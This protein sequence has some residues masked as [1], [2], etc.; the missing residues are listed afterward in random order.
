MATI[1]F[2]PETSAPAATIDFQ[3][4]SAPAASGIDFQPEQS[5]PA[6]NPRDFIKPA[7]GVLTNSGGTST[8]ITPDTALGEDF[9]HD[10]MA[11]AS[12]PAVALPKFTVNPDDSKVMAVAKSAAN[13]GISLP[14]FMESPL[15]VATMG[16]G[17]VIPKTVAALFTA[18]TA[19]SVGQQATQM[20]SQ[21][22]T[23]KPAEKAAALTDISGTTLLATTLGHHAAGKFADAIDTRVNPAGML[24]RELGRTPLNA[25]AAAEIPPWAVG[26]TPPAPPAEAVSPEAL[27]GL[28]SAMRQRQGEALKT[29]VAAPEPPAATLTP[30]PAKVAPTASQSAAQPIPAP[31]S[32]AQLAELPPEELTA[33]YEQHKQL[34][35]QAMDDGKIQDAVYLATQGQFYREALQNKS[36]PQETAAPPSQKGGTPSEVSGVQAPALQATQDSAVN[37]KGTSKEQIVKPESPPVSRAIPPASPATAP[38]EPV[39]PSI[40]AKETGKSSLE[41][42]RTG[43]VDT[44]AQGSLNQALKLKADTW[45]RVQ[46]IRQKIKA[47]PIQTGNLR[48]DLIK[49]ESAH[50]EALQMERDARAGIETRANEQG[51]TT[52]ATPPAPAEKPAAVQKVAS[53]M[54]AAAKEFHDLA[55]S[56]APEKK[57][58]SERTLDA[59][60]SADAGKNNLGTMGIKGNIERGKAIKKVWEAA[61]KELGLDPAQ[62][63]REAYRATHIEKIRT[64]AKQAGKFADAV[65]DEGDDSGK[66]S[67][68]S[69]ELKVGDSLDIGGEKVKVVAVRHDHIEL[70]DGRKFGKQTVPNGKTLYVEGYEPKGEPSGELIPESEMPFNL[71]GEQ[72]KFVEPTQETTQHGGE[73]LTQN[74]LFRIQEIVKDIDPEKSA[75]A[76]EKLYGGADKAAQTIARQLA[77]MA[78]DPKAYKSFGKEHRQRLESVVALLKERSGDPSSGKLGKEPPEIV[79]GFGGGVKPPKPPAEVLPPPESPEEAAKQEKVMTPGLEAV[80]NAHQGVLSLLFPTA[81]SADH[82]HAAETLGAKLGAMARRQEASAAQLAQSSKVFDRLGVENPKLAPGDNPGIKFMSDMSQ[83][84]PMSP[85][86]EAI[87]KLVEKQFDERTKALE[88][89][90]A[91]LQKV[92]ENYFPGMWTRESRM[93]FNAAMEKLKFPEGFDINEATPEQKAAIKAQVDEFM[94]GGKGSE[95]DMLSYITRTPMKGKESFR[96]EKVFD[97]IMTGAEVGLRPLSTN[98]I[99]LVKGKLA[100]MDR[101]IMANQFFQ[102]LK[103]EGKLEIISPYDEVPDGWVKVNDKYGTIYGAPTVTIPEHVDAAVYDGLVKF[104]QSIGVKHERSMKFPAGPGN[105]AL[106]L[107]Y[108]GQNFIRSKFATELSVIAHEIGH[109]IDYK[110]DLWQNITGGEKGSER[111]SLIQKDLR[112][113]ADMTGDRGGKV[114]SKPEKIAQMV[115]AYVHAPDAMRKEAPTVFTLFDNFIRSKPELKPLSDIKPGIALKK[116]T[117]E[118]YVG[119]PIMGY[120]IVPKATGDVLNNY[121]SSSLYN[122]QYFGGL[123]KAW[124]STANVL[125]QSQLGLGSAFHAGFTTSDVQISAGANLIKDIYGVARGNRSLSDLGGTVKDWVTAAGRTAYQGDKILNAWRNPDGVMSP[126]VAQI[127][128]AA[129]LAGGGFHMEHGMTTEQF[130]KMQRNWYSGEHLK[131]A[132]RSPIAMTELMMKPIMEWLVPRQKA[133][134]FADLAGRIIEHNP[135]KPLEELTPQFRQAWNRVD[136][137]LGQV[138]YNR[139]FVHNAAKNAAQALIRA[140]GW[141]GGTIAEI[142]GAFPDT[143]RFLREWV[144]TGKLPQDIPDRV[145]YTLSMFATIGAANAIATYAFTGQMPTG[146]D[147]LAFRTGR[148]D[149][150]GNNERFMFPSYVKDVLAYE[151]QPGSTLLNKAHPMFSML[152]DLEKNRDYMGYEIRD[153]NASAAVQAGQSAKFVVKNFEPFWLRGTFQNAPNAQRAAAAYIGIMP[154]PSY[155]DRSPIQNKIAELY[156]ERTGDRLKPYSARDTDAAKKQAHD[157]STMDVYMFRR[158]PKTDQAALREKMTPAELAR[159]H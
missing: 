62:I 150:N 70:E 18:D 57:W 63:G 72:G 22:D 147:Y 79:S 71:T 125:N 64:L 140:P 126:K 19:K 104:A 120:R 111:K 131:A 130:V 65:K 66:I 25:P 48:V 10:L 112:T 128:K 107:S 101:S 77:T 82:L 7:P 149:K 88:E 43:S 119:L 93:A 136:A 100:E 14:E 90:G 78:K 158:L 29:P 38:P 56:L 118:K 75:N 74:D 86:M 1:N 155:I 87:G 39:S 50:R 58:V 55:M 98:P 34:A 132:A 121:L 134:V 156:H 113:I 154:A 4:E 76:A 85:K 61:A 15:G 129:E 33:G 159:Y 117:G 106:G 142:G 16:A 69:D 3:P 20:G 139:L 44:P 21:W 148:K 2:E 144:K 99:D 41:K 53:P 27:A 124:M 105:R 47:N 123:F 103:G 83:G 135:G 137:R 145:A 24:A 146:L 31:L 110:Y 91:P 95:K 42:V 37:V 13:L 108:Q 116:L 12:R 49:A 67:V 35:R 94:E 143:G 8:K 109:Q 114:R 5:A 11:A 127:V 92:R 54:R 45:K 102:H 97:D 60:M 151:R 26:A 9:G 52:K 46:S 152:G 157:S 81:K 96:K 80:H 133:G 23:M 32:K 40:K 28:Q 59:A 6:V 84:R 153:P 122:N 68:E 141:S 115:E 30:E 89:A 138:R 17:G 73:T 51:Q 36:Q